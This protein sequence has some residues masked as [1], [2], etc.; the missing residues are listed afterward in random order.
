MFLSILFLLMSIVSNGIST[1]F[2]KF[3][4]LKRN[5]KILGISLLL[6]GFAAGFFKSVFFTKSLMN[7]DL[8]SAYPI[9]SSGSMI[10]I[11]F[12]SVFLFKESLSLRKISGIFVICLGIFMIA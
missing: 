2:Y 6:T 1:V 3:S 5:Q 4:S 9:F 8:N 10:L 7:I 12:I 11:I